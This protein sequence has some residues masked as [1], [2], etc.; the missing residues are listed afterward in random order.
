MIYIGEGKIFLSVEIDH[1]ENSEEHRFLVATIDA[2]RHRLTVLRQAMPTY[3][4]EDLVE[5]CSEVEDWFD[6]SG[7][8]LVP[9]HPAGESKDD[10]RVRVSNLEKK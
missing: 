3:G 7:N 6:E 9:Q 1:D 4:W 5:D 10:E 2:L 8:A